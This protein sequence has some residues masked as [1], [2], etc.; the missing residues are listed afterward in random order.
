MRTST[1]HELT[2]PLGSAHAGRL[3]FTRGVSNLTIVVDASMDELY[4]ARFDGRMPEVGVHGGT[5]TVRYRPSLLPSRGEITLSGLVPWN[6]TG[7]WGM[8]HVVA[9]LEDLDLGGSVMSG[10]CSHTAVRLP[11]PR[12]SVGVRIGGGAHD[13]ELVRPAGVPVRVRI[14]GGRRS[15]PSTISDSGRAAGRPTGGVRTTI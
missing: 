13:V 11:R 12:R 14:G 7:R 9:D 10:G 2:A 8:S 5:V 1:A 3:V 15:W 4:R 6:I